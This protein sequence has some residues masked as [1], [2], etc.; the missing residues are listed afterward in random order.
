VLSWCRFAGR[1]RSAPASWPAQRR[2]AQRH[3]QAMMATTTSNSTR[4]K[5]R[6]FMAA[7]SSCG[8]SAQ[9]TVGCVAAP[10]R[11]SGCGPA[12]TRPAA[13][14]SAAPR[15]PGTPAAPLRAF[16][17]LHQVAPQRGVLGLRSGA[18]LAPAASS[19]SIA[20]ACTTIVSPFSAVSSS[21]RWPGGI[22]PPQ[23]R[24]AARRTSC[25]GPPGQAASIRAARRRGIAEGPG[26]GRPDGRD[27]FVQGLDDGGR[28]SGTG[29][30]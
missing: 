28:Q 8:R 19:D 29:T 1:R 18:R 21:I 2:Q 12:A 5:A 17:A 3:Q 20:A 16:E 14:R 11:R 6:R 15:R 9:G 24:R 23:P 30:A 4:V 13:G 26:R 22:A 10:A 25:P 27:R 7:P